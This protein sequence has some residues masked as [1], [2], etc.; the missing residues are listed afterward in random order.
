MVGKILKKY[1][2]LPVQVRTSFWFLI[3][4]FLQKGISVI[5]SNM[6]S[7]MDTLFHEFSVDGKIGE[8]IREDNYQDF[9][10]IASKKRNAYENLIMNQLEK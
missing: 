1:K 10:N 2:S 9:A 6:N 4:A 5:M 8:P 7:R 3:C